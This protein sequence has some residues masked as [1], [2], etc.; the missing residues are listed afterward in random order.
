MKQQRDLSRLKRRMGRVGVWSSRLS[1]ESAA[2]TGA[3]VAE[4][5]DL[6][7]GTLWVGE[8][9]SSKEA[10]V[11]AGLLL[12]ATRDLMVATGILNIWGRDAT[13][14]S[15]GASALAEAYGDRFV[16]GLGVSHAPLVSDRGHHY[17]KPLSAMREYLD[18][19]DAVRYEGPLPTPAP[20]MLAALRKGM[21][22]L[23][24]ERTDGAHPYFVTPEHTALARSV[25]GPEPVLAPEQTVVLT[26][27][28]ERARK[29]GRAF[30]T[31]YLAMPNY[32][33]HMRSLGWDEQ[34]LAGGGT[35]ALVDAIVAW[36]T[37]EQV[38]DRIRAHH[39]AGA[40]HVCVQPL[41]ENA[42]DQ[43]AQLR[44]LAPL[45]TQG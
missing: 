35:D 39:D 6:G 36:G 16:L 4:I 20:R 29:I 45:L 11:H 40:D 14:T 30:T 43:M 24:A 17:R 31:G 9:P 28:A 2:A 38:A 1:R 15:N 26:T 42:A 10:L 12:G 37:P 5:E 8:T 19:L 13:T 21:L 25:L 41:A 7:Y 18:A 27:D 34:D 22:E 3:L 32:A 44:A 33:N 23:A